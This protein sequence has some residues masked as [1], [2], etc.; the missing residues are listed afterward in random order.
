MATMLGGEVGGHRLAGNLQMA[1][2]MNMSH[3][4]FGSVTWKEN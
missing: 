4:V 1:V 3:A 2:F